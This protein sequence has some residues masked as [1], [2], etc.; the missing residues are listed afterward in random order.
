MLRIAELRRE[1]AREAQQKTDEASLAGMGRRCGRLRRHLTVRCL[2]SPAVAIHVQGQDKACVRVASTNAK[3]GRVAGFC[4]LDQ[5]GG[6]GGSS[7]SGGS[8]G[9]GSSESRSDCAQLPAGA[10]HLWGIVP[11]EDRA[12]TERGEAGGVVFKGRR[13]T[14][15]DARTAPQA[16]EPACLAGWCSFAK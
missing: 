8:G 3:S 15:D 16:R 11:G 12:A 2:F 13:D 5:L 7:G 10:L 6:S 9:S 1:I 4:Y 14:G